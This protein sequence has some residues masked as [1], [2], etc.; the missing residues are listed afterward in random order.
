REMQDQ[1][2]AELLARRTKVEAEIREKWLSYEPERQR[3]LHEREDISKVVDK[4]LEILNESAKMRQEVEEPLKE[5]RLKN[6]AIKAE[7]DKRES[8]ILQGLY[9]VSNQW[10]ELNTIME[11]AH[12]EVE[13]IF[14]S[15]MEQKAEAIVASQAD[16][17]D[18]APKVR[19]KSPPAATGS[20]AEE[21]PMNSRFVKPAEDPE[22]A[23]ARVRAEKEEDERR[24]E[25]LIQ[26]DLRRQY[27]VRA[28]E[29]L[30]QAERERE[31]AI[32]Q[33]SKELKAT[34]AAASK[35]RKKTVASKPPQKMLRR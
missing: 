14:K 34:T 28:E 5:M 16:Q 1:K 32:L 25:E 9:N 17:A 6:A 8:E 21:P 22:E 11:N 30:R 26:Q 15:R 12:L 3:M 13:D 29:A 2:I 33:E 24:R 19:K 27:A 4:H 18:E 31:A 7:A 35:P 10:A 20:S 23:E